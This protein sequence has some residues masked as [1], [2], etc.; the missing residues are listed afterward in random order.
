MCF[1]WL[2]FGAATN[3]G[4]DVGKV[5]AALWSVRADQD[6]CGEQQGGYYNRIERKRSVDV[7]RKTITV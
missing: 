3:I 5:G 7:L 4:G 6:G 2:R 1:A